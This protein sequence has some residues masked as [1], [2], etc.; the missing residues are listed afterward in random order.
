MATGAAVVATGAAV[1][2]TGA[3]VAGV[4]VSGASVVVVLEEASLA[5]LDPEPPLS[6]MQLTMIEEVES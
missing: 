5:T 1:V 3:S 2:A 6:G 4:V